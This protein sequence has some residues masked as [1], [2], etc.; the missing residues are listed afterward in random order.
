MLLGWEYEKKIIPR[1]GKTHVRWSAHGIENEEKKIFKK[2]QNTVKR[3]SLCLY[4]LLH[5]LKLRVIPL[6]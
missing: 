5:K 3:K 2:R 4:G 1:R 6:D